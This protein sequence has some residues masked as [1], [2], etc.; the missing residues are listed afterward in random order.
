MA[1]EKGKPSGKHN[2]SATGIPSN[3]QPNKQ[4]E[5]NN[6]TDEFTQD[7]EKI[8]DHVKTKHPN[9]NVD[10]NNATNAGGYKN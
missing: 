4:E 7:D 10:K 2:E 3:I 5:D 9:R 1:R 8:A 6:L